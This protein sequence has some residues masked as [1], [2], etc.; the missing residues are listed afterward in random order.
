M[1]VLGI[2]CCD[3]EVNFVMSVLF[4]L[5]VRENL[6]TF[7]IHLRVVVCSSVCSSLYIFIILSLL[8]HGSKALVFLIVLYV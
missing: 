3:G 7:V 2:F 6:L 8:H 5:I 4:S 1:L